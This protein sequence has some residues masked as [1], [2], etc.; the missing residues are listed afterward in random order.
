MQNLIE[1]M[2]TFI[3]MSACIWVHVFMHTCIYVCRQM[4]LCTYTHY[5][6]ASIHICIY[7]GHVIPLVS[8]LASHD[9]N[10]TAVFHRPKQS[11]WG[12][13]WLF[14]HLLQLAP[15]LSCDVH[16]IVNGTT[17]FL[18]ST[19]SKWG[20]KWLWSCDVI[21][22]SVN[23]MWFWY[24]YVFYNECN[25]LGMYIGRHKWVCLYMPACLYE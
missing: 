12:A 6:H 24:I 25:H 20:E 5:I 23:I 17:A 19:W 1:V 9:S 3:Y 22:P 13:T 4:Y 14:C 11:K 2:F 8:A 15:F 18:R 16:G 7:I 10:D 21:G